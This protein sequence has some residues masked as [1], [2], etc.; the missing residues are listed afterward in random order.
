[1]SV[2]S[3]LA[4]RL[5]VAFCSLVILGNAN[6]KVMENGVDPENLGKGDWIYFLSDAVKQLG[7][8]VPAVTDLTSLM[9]YYKEVGMSF[10]AIKA[11]TGARE[12]PTD[13]PQFT[14]E[15]IEAAHAAGLKVYPYTR[16]D[17]KDV[18]GEIALALKCYDMGADGFII[19][20]ESEWEEHHLGNKNLQLAIDLCE[21]IRAKYPNKFLAHAPLPVISLHSSFPYKEFG[22]YCDAVMPQ[23]Y[24]KSI[25]VTP[26]RMVKWMNEEWHRWQDSLTGK[27]TNAIKP[28]APIGQGW[29]PT[30]TKVVT[31]NEILEFVAALNHD[32]NPITPT[33]YTGVSYWRTDL[34]TDRMWKGIKRAKLGD[35]STTPASL[36]SGPEPESDKIVG[37]PVQ[38]PSNFI[39]DDDAEEVTREGSWQPG[40]NAENRHGKTYWCSNSD[41]EPATMTYR[42]LMRNRGNYDVFIW[43]SH[44]SNRSTKAQWIIS[45]AN[46]AITNVVDQTQNGG[47]WYL[48]ASGVPF[49]SGTNGFVSVSNATGEGAGRIVVADAIRFVRQEP[50]VA[51]ET[52]EQPQE[53]SEQPATP[54]QTAAA[55]PAAPSDNP[56]DIVLD[57]TSSGVSFNGAWFPG[58]QK[59][60]RYGDSH[61]C[62]N[63]KR[64]ETSATAVYRPEIQ[65]A[66]IYDIYIWY[67]TSGNRS[68]KAPWVITYDGGVITNYV[69][70]TEDGGG[71]YLIAAN[72]HL[73]AGTNT[74]VGISNQTSESPQHVV[75][76]DAV[77]FVRKQKTAQNGGE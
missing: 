25:G 34:H 44:H 22:Y 28:I 58:K 46:G 29:N 23:A 38:N 61:M 14:P 68:T 35:L 53:S 30:E 50:R 6:A 41:G 70:Q 54:K 11:G 51:S 43:Y 15:F 18:P 40:A 5:F 9:E 72:L 63:A 32:K 66:G 4:T 42:P 75:I 7:G 2:Q 8:N 20:A 64:T 27:W 1:M 21:G 71:W 65:N 74:T 48:L 52:T 24:W 69:N 67:C 77:R 49:L 59:G 56:D 39:I 76:A 57:D 45:G 60:G 26:K 33:G 47:D 62:A 16:S 3:N 36:L 12:F 73:S 13:N 37:R 55:T 31:G 10:V 17:G 19:D